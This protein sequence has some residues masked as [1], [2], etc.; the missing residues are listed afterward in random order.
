MLSSSSQHDLVTSSLQSLH[1]SAIRYLFERWGTALNV[2]PSYVEFGG[3]LRSYNSRLKTTPKEI[4]R[5]NKWRL[6]KDRQ[7]YTDRVGVLMFGPENVRLA[8]K[9]M[10][11]DDF[12]FY[13]EMILGVEL[14]IGI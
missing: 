12:A 9:V 8:N 5:D 14:S 11:G 6:S 7:L 1:D 3:T 13:Q 4:E 2:V 10:A